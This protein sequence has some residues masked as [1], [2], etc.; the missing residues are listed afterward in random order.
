[1]PHTQPNFVSSRHYVDVTERF[2][3][4][5]FW[6]ADKGM[7]EIR[8]TDGFFRITGFSRGQPV[9][10]Q[11]WMSIL[12]PE[13]YEDFRSISSIVSMDVSV[14]REVRLIEPRRPYR[15]VRIS[16]E[17]SKTTGRL[18]G[19]IQDLANERGVRAALYRERAR[20]DTFLD[21][22][23]TIFWALNVAGALIDLRGWEEITGQNQ[24]DCQ[25]GGWA[26]LIH[27]DDRQ[28][29]V[30]AWSSCLTEGS[31]FEGR[32]RLRY[33]D[34]MY[35]VVLARC[36]PVREKNGAPIEWIGCLQEMW[37]EPALD[38]LRDGKAILKPQQL[39][40]A[41]AMLGWSADKL[42][43]EAGVSPATIRRYETTDEHMKEATVSAIL[44]AL[45]SHGIVVTTSSEKIALSLEIR[46]PTA[47]EA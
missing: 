23:R 38:S 14:S 11:R 41:R 32:F 12:H 20:L 25:N 19:L 10:F 42:A 36:T 30:M 27:P 9:T 6:N 7:G 46:Q 18:V 24:D 8:G 22:T 31:A 1:M 34:D 29:I 44:A 33:L 28:R 37:R 17:Q 47:G 45:N 43:S 21:T 4:I 40:A 16:A 26:D 3:D 13:D 2:I 15:W 35:R 39:R 5:G